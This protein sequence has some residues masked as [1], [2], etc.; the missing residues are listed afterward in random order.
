MP[1]KIR[2]EFTG[3]V[4]DISLPDEAVGLIMSVAGPESLCEEI[5]T[6]IGWY[7]FQ[8]CCRS[9]APAAGEIRDHLNNVASQVLRLRESIGLLPEEFKANS[10]VRLLKAKNEFFESFAERLERDLITLQVLCGLGVAEIQSSKSGSKKQEL[11]HSLLS[12]VSALFEAI[13]GMQMTKAAYIAAEVLKA[14]GVKAPDWIKTDGGV[15]AA[16]DGGAARERV[17]AY[18]KTKGV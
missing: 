6:L 5:G 10:S 13:P 15:L 7:R 8:E 17:R 2:E 9:S 16:G 18:R 3:G 11:E 14:A 12:E 1:K 4:V